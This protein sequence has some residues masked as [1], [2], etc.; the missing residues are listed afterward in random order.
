MTESLRILKAIEFGFVAAVI[1]L[2]FVIAIAGLVIGF[3]FD[4]WPDWQAGFVSIVGAIFGV[5]AAAFG[6]RAALREQ[7]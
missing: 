3:D 5:A 6:V 7:S 1:A 2:F 4:K